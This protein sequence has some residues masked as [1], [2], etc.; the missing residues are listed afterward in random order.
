MC[1]LN[2]QVM[3]IND[4]HMR[5]PSTSTHL[6]DNVDRPT[7]A[8][9]VFGGTLVWLAGRNRYSGIPMQ[10]IQATCILYRLSQSLTGILARTDKHTVNA[11]LP[12]LTGLSK[13]MGERNIDS[14]HPTTAVHTG[15]NRIGIIYTSYATPFQTHRTQPMKKRA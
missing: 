15:L 14:V 6:T 5:T 8:G 3:I 9:G 11:I 12:D 10:H 7:V 2:P 4:Y 1:T 13:L